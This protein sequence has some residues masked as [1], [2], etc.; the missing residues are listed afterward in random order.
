MDQISISRNSTFLYQ[1]TR[2]KFC[3][4]RETRHRKAGTLPNSLPFP[5]RCLGF[6]PL[7]GLIP[8]PLISPTL[9]RVSGAFGPGHRNRFRHKW[10][11]L[12]GFVVI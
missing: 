1:R 8:S 6:S 11:Q 10:W 2:D 12:L 9:E 7:L 5:S 3:D 4:T